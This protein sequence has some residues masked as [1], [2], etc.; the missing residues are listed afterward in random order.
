[1]SGNAADVYLFLW[2]RT[3]TDNVELTGDER[4]LDIW[5]DKARVSW[6]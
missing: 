3:G 6:S 1:V 2:N 4:V 5:R